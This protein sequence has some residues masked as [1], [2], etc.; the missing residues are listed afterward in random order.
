MKKRLEDVSSGRDP[1]A[2]DKSC[3]TLEGTAVLERSSGMHKVSQIVKRKGRDT[4]C[5]LPDSKCRLAPF[6]DLS[7]CRNQ[8]TRV[9]TCGMT[10]MDTHFFHMPQTLILN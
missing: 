1:G 7:M 5:W 9:K 10:L 8:H 4:K 3:F 2:V 6:P